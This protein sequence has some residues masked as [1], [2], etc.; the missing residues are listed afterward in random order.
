MI[1]VIFVCLGN[2]C[3][4]PMAEF[5]FKKMIEE[6]GLQNEIIVSSRGTSYEEEGNPVHYK[7]REILSKY[8]I[9][10][11]GKYAQRLSDEDLK[12]DYLIAM[13][14]NNLYNIKRRLKNNKAEVKRLLEYADEERDIKDPYYTLDFNTTYND[15]YKGCKELLKYI[16]NKHK[17]L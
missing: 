5:V 11:K 17:L 10:T 4:S 13:D 12:A 16:K 15:I 6:E 3:R 8:R 1:K 2:I 7:T 9:D 14:E